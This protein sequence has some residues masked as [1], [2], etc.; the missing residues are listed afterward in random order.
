MFSIIVS[1]SVLIVLSSAWYIYG[2]L[3]SRSSA[4]ERD[5]EARKP[6]H[7]DTDA[8]L[9]DTA[10]RLCKLLKEKLPQCVILPSDDDDFRKSMN[11]YWA[12]QACEVAPACFVRPQDTSQLSRTIKILK[13]EFDKQNDSNIR[14]NRELVTFAVRSGGHSPAVGASSIPGGVMI[15]LSLFNEI[16]PAADEKSVLIGVGNK[17][18]HVSDRLRTM[19]LAVAGGRNSAVGVGGLALGG[20]LSFFSPRCGFVCSNIIELQIVLADGTITTASAT[21]NPDLWRALKGGANNFGI[22]TTIR[23]RSFPSTDIWSGFLYMHSFQANKALASFHG[24][25]NKVVTN[26]EE[27]TYDEYASGPIQCFSYVQSLGIQ[28]VSVAMTHTKQPESR[29]NWPSCWQSS[30]YSKLW[31]FWSTCGTKT[32]TAATDEM[33]VLNPPGRRQKFATTTVKNDLATLEAV[34][35]AYSDA[36]PKIRAGKIRKMDWTLILQPM[37]PDWAR[38]GDPN[39]LGLDACTDEPLVNISFSVNWALAKDDD[40]VKQITREAIEQIETFAERQGTG[41][42]YR[43]IN[44]CDDW[45]RPFEGYGQDN[46]DFMRDVSR[47][48]DPQGLFQKGC[49]GGF[50]LGM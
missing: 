10:R 6:A 22:V 12:Q 5:A 43:Y 47:K 35:R 50:K 18:F 34:H 33:S 37:L 38:K 9:S 30:G 11:F 23:A 20:G 26:E 19:G 41:H 25:L 2:R 46:I 14:D 45:Q 15:D 49:V 28:V 8:D 1:S 7:L 27:K 48:Y 3:Q 16:S 17:W 13:D 29:K 42:R 36:I 24:F 31:R 21:K 40:R 39:V 4:V 44:Y 32:L